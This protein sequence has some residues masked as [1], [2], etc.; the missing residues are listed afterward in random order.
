MELF[1]HVISAGMIKEPK[2]ALDGYYKMIEFSVLPPN[3]I[4]YIGDDVGKDVLPAKQVGILTGL[5]WSKSD[6]A[7]YCF[8]G[9]E[10]ILNIFN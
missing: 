7:D 1:T 8:G 3:E 4:L 2:P 6:E 10:E 5:M 9:F